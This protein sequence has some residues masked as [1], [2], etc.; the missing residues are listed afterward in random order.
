MEKLIFP[1]VFVD[2]NL[3]KALINS[4]NLVTK[5]FNRHN[6]SILCTLHR[7]SFIEAFGLEEQM[8]VPIDIDDL[9]G[10]FG[11]NKTHYLNNV[12]LPH[13]RYNVKKRKGKY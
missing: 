11:R 1:K 9:Q 12:M 8:D 3:V 10:K 6:G 5:S 4:Y 2:V 13:I 7:T